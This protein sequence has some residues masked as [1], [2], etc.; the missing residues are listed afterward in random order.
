MIVIVIMGVI[1]TLGVTSFPTKEEEVE[2]LSL[3]TLKKYLAGLEYEE[4]AKLLCLDDCKTCKI[5]IDGDSNT[6]I[7][8]FVD[9]DIR[10]Y[11]YDYLTGATEVMRDVYFNIEN[12]QEDVCFSYKVDKQ[13]IGDQVLV[14]FK[15]E[16]YDFTSSIEAVKKYDSLEE[17]IDAKSSLVQ[18]V[19]R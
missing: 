9:S 4:S 10:V 8:S 5:L 12:I 13:G 18:A 2:H 19:I 16:V 17:A 14:E 3:L 6:T 15:E 1:Y 7:D 11:R